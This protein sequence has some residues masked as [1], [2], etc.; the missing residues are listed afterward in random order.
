MEISIAKLFSMLLKQWKII[1][2]AV[3]AGFF[4]ALLV[5]VFAIKPTYQSTAKFRVYTASQTSSSNSAANNINNLNFARQIIATYV[6]C[7]K[8]NE[9][10]QQVSE[11]LDNKFT[12]DQIRS[13]VK[14]SV[15]ADTL[16]FNT[17]VTASS[18]EEALQVAQAVVSAV[19]DRISNANQN[20]NE[21]GVNLVEKPIAPKGKAS[22][23]TT[24]NCLIGLVLG[25]MV[26]VAFILLKEMLDVR[27]K[28]EDS[29]MERYNIPVLGTVPDFAIDRKK[30]G[31]S[32]G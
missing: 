17:V 23:S 11:Q 3:L 24:R 12:P 4:A 6:E 15:S 9:F 7:L 29:L 21:A 22:P 10:Y 32:R 8:V 19:P 5:T 2:A 31:L 26:S 14:F 20:S 18:P 13:M 1:V 25:G 30:R 16:I 27:I 28:G